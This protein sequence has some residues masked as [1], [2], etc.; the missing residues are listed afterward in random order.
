MTG[1]LD[2]PGE[3]RKLIYEYVYPFDRTGF[4]STRARLGK[5]YENDSM[6]LIQQ[7]TTCR[8]HDTCRIIRDEVL[9]FQWSATFDVHLKKHADLNCFIPEFSDN[10]FRNIKYLSLSCDQTNCIFILCRA[11]G[12]DRAMPHIHLEEG[13]FHD[14]SCR[15]LPNLRKSLSVPLS[16]TWLIPTSF[17]LLR[18]IAS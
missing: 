15:A 8:L 6:L 4:P 18:F 10:Q 3:L 9:R 16:G 1:F 2:L 11:F 7:W 12:Y 14:N 5:C 13:R 17:T